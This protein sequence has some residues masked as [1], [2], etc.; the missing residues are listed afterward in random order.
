MTTKRQ[1]AGRAEKLAF[2]R[3]HVSNYLTGDMTAKDYCQKQ[4]LI[5]H[6][7]KYWQYE[8]EKKRSS[9]LSS[10]SQDDF[11]E[12]TAPPVQPQKS[13]NLFR[14]IE[15]KTHYGFSII[16]HEALAE[17]NLTTLLSTIKRLS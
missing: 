9:E 15:I 11:V 16:I 5:L 2:W 4:G 14:G 1:L 3:P 6:Q 17:E 7:L 8:I 12:I 13:S 10:M